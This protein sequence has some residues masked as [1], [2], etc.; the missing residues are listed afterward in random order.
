METRLCFHI[1]N[2]DKTRTFYEQVLKWPVYKEW[3]RSPEDRGVVYHA[4]S[5]LLEFL[6]SS[7]ETATSFDDTFYIYQE[8]ADLEML[9]KTLQAQGAAPTHIET[10]PWGHKNFI[11]KDPSGLRLKFFTQ[12]N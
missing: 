11:V 4:G 6:L 10:Q 7:A 3:D 1:Y 5:V 8:V 9:H 12:G 2:Y